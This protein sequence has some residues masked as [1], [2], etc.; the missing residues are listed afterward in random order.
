MAENIRFSIIIPIYKVEKFICECIDSVINQTLKKIE[1]ILVDDGSPDNCPKI[2]DEYAQ[3]DKRI[4][5]I[6]KANG[7]LSSARNTGLKK[8]QGEY[9]LFLDSD[10]YYFRNDFL[11]IL[12]KKVLDKKLD[13]VF[14][15]RRRFV[16]SIKEFLQ[17]PSPYNMLEGCGDSI[18]Y[19][20]A[21]KDK[22]EA[23]AAMKLIKRDYLIKNDLYFKEGIYSEDV[24]WFFRFVQDL[25]EV[26]VIETVAYCY[27]LREGSITHSITEKNITDLIYSVE[28]YSQ[29]ILQ[30]IDEKKKLALLNYL[31][32]QYFIALNLSHRFLR[33]KAKKKIMRILKNYKWLSNYAISGK[34]KK[35]AFAVKLFGIK[36]GAFLMAVYYKRKERK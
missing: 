17:P 3:K 6:H 33:G 21:K 18:L 28:T 31:A 34:T 26:D 4:T 24:E 12:D 11:E 8:A 35:A 13:A 15:Q 19:Q 7:G 20:L 36:I 5:V 23:S 10:D 16:D 14:F 30:I 32:Y 29:Q 22:L 27:R 25:K 2:C 1:I 9:V